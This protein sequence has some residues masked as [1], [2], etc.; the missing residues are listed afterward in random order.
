MNSDFNSFIK[1][2]EAQPTEIKVGGNSPIE[3]KNPD[4]CP[5]F[6]ILLPEHF[7]NKDG[8]PL[9]DPKTEDEEGNLDVFRISQSFSGNLRDA[10]INDSC[11]YRLW[12]G[13][14][15]RGGE[16]RHGET[17]AMR[18]GT[19]FEFLLTGAFDYYGDKPELKKKYEGTPSESYYA[20]DQRAIDN[21]NA[22]KDILKDFNIDLDKKDE[23]EVDKRM[24]FK[25][26]GISMDLSFFNHEIKDIK[27]SGVLFD[28][29]SKYAWD[30]KGIEESF[31]KQIQSTLYSLVYMLIIGV[32]PNFEYIVFS[33]KAKELKEF[34]IF[35]VTISE[36]R[37][38]MLKWMMLDV[39]NLFQ[40]MINEDK[41][42]E[43]PSFEN[44][45]GCPVTDCKVRQKYRKVIEV[46][47]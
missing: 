30:E 43:K 18:L 35:K 14:V 31:S 47:I 45:K 40:S 23:Y 7:W 5:D 33:N 22:A 42:I 38:N 44:C 4:P 46:N 16:K 20:A 6:E 10:L 21:A 11:L 24:V 19:L 17:D 3:F 36:E 1:Q 15:L 25:C 2:V 12:F 26:L 29:W 39:A 27:Y 13:S 41:F 8:T 9:L 37:F 32:K 34:Q 28:D